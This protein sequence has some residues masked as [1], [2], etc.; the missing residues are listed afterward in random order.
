MAGRVP[1]HLG[2]DIVRGATEGAGLFVSKYVLL[3]HPKVRNLDV[4]I[5][6]QH[7]IVQLEVP[8]GQGQESGVIRSQVPSYPPAPTSLF[9]ALQA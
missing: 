7:H 1:A 5:P 3:A 9:S 4:A 8:E 2:G 6:V